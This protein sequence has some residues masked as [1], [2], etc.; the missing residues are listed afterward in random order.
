MGSMPNHGQNHGSTVLSTSPKPRMI[1]ERPDDAL[2]DAMQDAWHDTPHDPWLPSALGMDTPA[3]A[4]ER[5]AFG[6]DR[7]ATPR[8]GAAGVAQTP[9]V[10]DGTTALPPTMAP[11]ADESLLTALLA[12]VAQHD[13]Q[14]FQQLYA[15]TATRLH[16]LVLHLTQHAA[17]ADEVL[18]AVYWQVWRDAPRYNATRGRA[19][20]WLMVMARSRALDAWRRERRHGHMRTLPRAA[21]DGGD[22]NASSDDSGLTEALQ[23]RVNED[24]HPDRLLE[25]VQRD[26]RLHAA[27]RTL[28]VLQRQL[29]DLAFFNDCTHEEIAAA[30]QLPLGTVKSHIRR[31][32]LQLRSLLVTPS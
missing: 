20:A 6:I 27:L 4:D 18:E 3:H 15:A 12:R 7:R 29:V 11:H 1:Q 22:R 16:A 14:A 25:L 19:M 31:T 5:P 9:S 30:M 23:G 24:V 10:T 13:E 32:L 21:P 8:L 2:H 17:W 26:H 28:P